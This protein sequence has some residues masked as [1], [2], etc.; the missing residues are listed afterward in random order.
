[1]ANNSRKFC[2]V[3]MDGRVQKQHCA[4]AKDRKD[5]ATK[6]KNFKGK[7]VEVRE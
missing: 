6:L 1:M 3:K 2:K 7:I 5:A 4:M